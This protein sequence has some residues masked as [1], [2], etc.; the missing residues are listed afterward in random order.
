MNQQ[1]SN[2]FSD[3]KRLVNKMHIPKEK[4][5]ELANQPDSHRLTFCLVTSQ[6]GPRAGCRRIRNGGPEFRYL[7]LLSICSVE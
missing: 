6:S 3:A 4:G 5:V 2:T 7:S 1:D